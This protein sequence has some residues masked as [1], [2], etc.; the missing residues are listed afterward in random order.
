MRIAVALVAILFIFTIFTVPGHAAGYEAGKIVRERG[1]ST[2]GGLHFD[3]VNDYVKI[4]LNNVINGNF[5]AIVYVNSLELFHTYN[6]Y[7][8][9]QE[10][11]KS[12]ATIWM[13]Y[14]NNKSYYATY[15]NSGVKYYFTVGNSINFGVNN[16]QV[17]RYDGSKLKGWYGTLTNEINFNYSY[18]NPNIVRIGAGYFNNEITDLFYSNIY[19]V[20]LY[21]RS[22]TDAEISQVYDYLHNGTGSPV[23]NGSMLML[24]P[25]GL[26]IENEKWNDESGHGNNGTIY[27]AMPIPAVPSNQSISISEN[28]VHLSWS[29]SRYAK[30]YNVYRAVKT[31]AGENYTLLASTTRTHYDDTIDAGLN[32]TYYIT[33]VN[34]GENN[35]TLESVHAID[36][37]AYIYSEGSGILSMGPDSPVLWIFVVAGAAA[38]V[39]LS[40]E[41]KLGR[42]LK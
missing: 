27:G 9:I 14:V 11:G 2:H 5:T 32:Y 25:S 10:E 36:L 8:S 29:A 40:V 3:G 35:T 34:T 19:F 18:G 33:A 6:T 7:L 23:T 22:L 37:Y 16:F 17:L 30:Y 1:I 38:L 26:N 28:T 12:S 13:Q 41:E 4:N 21:N 31:R 15:N 24:T 39:M 20:A 42:R